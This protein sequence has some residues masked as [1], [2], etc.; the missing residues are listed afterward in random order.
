[1]FGFH[2]LLFVTASEMRKF[3]ADARLGFGSF[4]DKELMPYVDV[5]GSRC[6]DCD[7]PYSFIHGLSLTDNTS[8]FVRSL[9]QIVNQ[10]SVFGSIDEP[11]GGLDALMQAIV[12]DEVSLC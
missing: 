6:S 11:Q 3:T 4:V 9:T 5:L 7:Q 8:G 12:C 2:N 1:M 10:S